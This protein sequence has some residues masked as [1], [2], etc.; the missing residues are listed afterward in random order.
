MSIP[1]KG[2]TTRL[3][4][5]SAKEPD[6]IQAF[7]RS[8]ER[9]VQVHDIVF[10]KGRWYLWFIPGDQDPDIKGGDLDG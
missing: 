3:R 10:A 6:T 5:V 2:L 9:R 4:W 8:L 1:S 7:L